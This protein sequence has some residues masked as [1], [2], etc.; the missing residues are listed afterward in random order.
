MKPLSKRATTALEVLKAG[1]F[2][3]KQQGYSGSFVKLYSADRSEVEGFGHR[4]HAKSALRELAG[5]GF[6]FDDDLDDYNRIISRLI[7][8]GTQP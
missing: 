2:F 3:A 8:A 6:E 5:A 7:P 4:G 1:G